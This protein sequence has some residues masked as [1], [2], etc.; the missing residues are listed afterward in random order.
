MNQAE[1]I[2]ARVKD[3]EGEK[4]KA[5]A[6]YTLEPLLGNFAAPAA[7]AVVDNRSLKSYVGV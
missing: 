2:R 6:V 5:S 4:V 7:N 3:P 1:A